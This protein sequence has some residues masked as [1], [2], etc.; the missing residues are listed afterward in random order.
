[1]SIVAPSAPQQAAVLAAAPLHP[2]YPV[3][4][5]FSPDYVPNTLHPV[6]LLLA[7][8]SVL[9]GWLAVVR[10]HV[11]RRTKGRATRGDVGW[12]LWS[13]WSPSCCS[14][15][16]SFA[17]SFARAPSAPRLALSSARAKPGSA[18]R[19]CTDLPPSPP[20]S[21]LPRRFGACAAI[22]LTFEGACSSAARPDCYAQHSLLALPSPFPPYPARS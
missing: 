19:S 6:V 2:F 7:F 13:V 22:H 11:N 12:A 10:W 8:F 16:P 14:P 5:T 4:I 21:F 3:A 20:S 9:A 15:P 17:P 1:M 18:R